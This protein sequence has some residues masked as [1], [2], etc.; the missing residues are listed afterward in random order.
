LLEL[1]GDGNLL[2]GHIPVEPKLWTLLMTH[3]SKKGEVQITE[4]YLDLMIK[5]GVEPDQVALVNAKP[6]GEVEAAKGT[7]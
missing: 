3:A 2:N 4:D 5:N 6:K 1:T 7:S